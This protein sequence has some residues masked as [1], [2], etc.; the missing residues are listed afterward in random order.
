MSGDA[1]VTTSTRKCPPTFHPCVGDDTFASISG[2]QTSTFVV[3]EYPESCVPAFTTRGFVFCGRHLRTSSCPFAPSMHLSCPGVRYSGGL[4]L[5]DQ[6]APSAAAPRRPG[7]SRRATAGCRSTSPR[8]ARACSPGSMEKRLVSALAGTGRSSKVTWRSS[9]PGGG[10]NVTCGMRRRSCSTR[11][12][13]IFMT[14]VS[15][16]RTPSS[17]AFCASRRPSSRW[18]ERASHEERC[19][20]VRACSSSS[21]D[22]WSC[23][24]QSASLPGHVGREPGARLLEGVD[25][26]P[27]RD[28]ARRGGGCGPG[29]APPA[30]RRRRPRGWAVAPS[31]PPTGSGCPASC[32]GQ[33]RPG[34]RPAAP[35]GTAPSPPP[36]APSATPPSRAGCAGAPGPGGRTCRTGPARLELSLGVREVARGVVPVEHLLRRPD[37]GGVLPGAP[38][39]SEGRARGRARARRRLRA[40]RGDARASGQSARPL[41]Y[42][43]ARANRAFPRLR[44]P[45]VSCSRTRR[46]R[47]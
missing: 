23:S 7:T 35:S 26:G 33:L 3:S 14:A 37:G 10:W 27:A 18:A 44:A 36:A 5:E 38:A 17:S 1:A 47:R 21:S 28:V 31:P 4:R 43:R 16:L 13:A 2:L 15:R 39:P 40:L 22:F 32:A 8:R 6:L 20:R 12:R 30:S 19:R 42:Q 41:P 46:R 29:W 45:P 24:M 9:V 34:I 11:S 25:V